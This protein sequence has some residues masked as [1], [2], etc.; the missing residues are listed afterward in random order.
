MSIPAIF[1]FYTDSLEKEI[2]NNLTKYFFH[3]PN[4]KKTR[5]EVSNRVFIIY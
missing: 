2:E 3:V 1:H 4:I 5:L